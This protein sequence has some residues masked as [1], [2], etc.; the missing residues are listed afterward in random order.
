MEIGLD[1]LTI[2][3]G[4]ASELADDTGTVTED[5]GGSALKQSAPLC[6]AGPEFASG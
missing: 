4:D 6:H 1:D 5:G 3:T 2:V